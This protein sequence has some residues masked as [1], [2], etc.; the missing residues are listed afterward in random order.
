MTAHHHAPVET[1]LGQLS[2]RLS[3]KELNRVRRAYEFAE[4]WHQ[5]Q[6]RKSR[7]P[8]ITRPQAV[9]VAAADVEADCT[10]ACAALL[11]DVLEGTGCDPQF[12]RA[13]FGDEIAGLID[14]L[15]V[16]SHSVVLPEDDRQVL[17]LKLQDR[18]HNM[19]TILP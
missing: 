17:M 18:L 11:H 5:G 9:S 8:Y 7:D 13:E 4:C 2:G 12:L 10:V 14:R 19:Q 3:P 15:M 1:L 6:R 16:F